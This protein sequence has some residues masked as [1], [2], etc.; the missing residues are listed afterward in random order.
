MPS[1]RESAS[2]RRRSRSSPARSAWPLRHRLSMER[3]PSVSVRSARLGPR[4]RRNRPR[5]PGRWLGKAS[6]LPQR[7]RAACSS[8]SVYTTETE[9]YLVTVQ[10]DPFRGR[11]LAVIARCVALLNH[12]QIRRVEAAGRPSSSLKWGL[13]VLG[14]AYSTTRNPPPV[15]A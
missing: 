5:E 1:C 7:V 9:L 10:L 12:A 13:R 15:I 3:S 11:Y 8:L 2:L 6:E 4:G 14:K